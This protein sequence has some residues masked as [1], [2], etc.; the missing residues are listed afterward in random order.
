MHTTVKRNILF[1][2]KHGLL[3]IALECI[4]SG[5]KFGKKATIYLF[6]TRFCFHFGDL[7]LLDTMA[8]HYHIPPLINE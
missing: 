2:I 5:R 7:F 1:C 8:C 6:H 4:R 3:L